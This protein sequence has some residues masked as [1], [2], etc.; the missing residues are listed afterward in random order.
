MSR[1]TP[2]VLTQEQ[3]EVN[4]E[5][6]RKIQKDVKKC[7]GMHY[8][9]EESEMKATERLAVLT[10]ML[11]VAQEISKKAE[12]KEAITYDYIYKT[13]GYE[14]VLGEFPNRRPT[15]H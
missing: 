15:Y 13:L 10:R 1:E 5:I 6:I 11:K 14:Y 12:K 7:M 2:K 9:T 4:L 8:G 3:K